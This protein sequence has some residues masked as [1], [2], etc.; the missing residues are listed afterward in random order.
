VQHKMNHIA[1]KGIGV[2]S[3]QFRTAVEHLLENMSRD[4]WELVSTNVN[5]SSSMMN[6]RSV[7]ALF[8]WKR[9]D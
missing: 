8:F 2:N 4:G 7:D 6:N 3:D 5:E 1:V 9:P